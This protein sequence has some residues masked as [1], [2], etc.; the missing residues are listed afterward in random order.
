MTTGTVELG[1]SRARAPN[2]IEVIKELVR[3]SVLSPPPPLQYRVTNEH[4]IFFGSILYPEQF[5]KNSSRQSKV[6]GVQREQKGLVVLPYIQGVS[7][8]TTRT[9]NRH[10]IKVA[11]QSVTTIRSTFKKPRTS[12]GQTCKQSATATVCNVNYKNC[13]QNCIA[14][15]TRIKEDKKTDLLSVN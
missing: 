7:E 10:N 5:I 14:I 9:L 13:E 11:H 12:R 6:T 15:K 2:I 1:G 3:K 8:R 4:N